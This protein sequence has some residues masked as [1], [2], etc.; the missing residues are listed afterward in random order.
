[1]HMHNRAQAA[2]DYLATAFWGSPMRPLQLED[3]IYPDRPPIIHT[4]LQLEEGPFT[5]KEFLKAIGRTRGRKRGP[6]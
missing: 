2:A 1:M 3:C 5:M 6:R 4:L